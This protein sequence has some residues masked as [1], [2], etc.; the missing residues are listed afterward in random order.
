MDSLGSTSGTPQ[1]LG[2]FWGRPGLAILFLEWFF[3]FDPPSFIAEIPHGSL[4][5]LFFGSD[6]EK[7]LGGGYVGLTSIRLHEIM[8]A[9]WIL[10]GCKD[11]LHPWKQQH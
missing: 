9:S 4:G 5:V 7:S 1:K 11:S 6:F 3:Q 2:V 10:Q 8:S